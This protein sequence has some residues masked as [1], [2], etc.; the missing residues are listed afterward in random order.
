MRRI[1]L[2]VVAIFPPPFRPENDLAD[3]WFRERS[4]AYSL[5]SHAGTHRRLPSG[6]YGKS[7]SGNRAGQRSRYLPPRYFLTR[8]SALFAIQSLASASISKHL[9]K[10]CSPC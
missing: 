10:I 8:A 3:N 1:C 5:V 6:R 4:I 7:H 9:T 2:A